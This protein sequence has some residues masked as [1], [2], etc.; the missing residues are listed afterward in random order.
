[1]PT[2]VAGDLLTVECRPFGRAAKFRKRC[3][4]RMERVALEQKDAVPI[5]A[6][7]RMFLAGVRAGTDCHDE[8]DRSKTA[9]QC[10]A[11]D[12]CHVY[13][14]LPSSIGKFVQRF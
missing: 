7:L 14:A 13:Q 4:K 3:S 1:M 9:C 10:R 11:V 5:R 2:Q 8:V 6:G 12:L